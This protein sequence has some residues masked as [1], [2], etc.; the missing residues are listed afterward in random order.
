MHKSRLVSLLK[1][2]NKQEF[3][4]L[5]RF[6]RSPFFNNNDEVIALYDYLKNNN[7]YPNFTA[8]VLTKE[9][10]D[11]KVFGKYTLPYEYDP[12]RIRDCMSHL[13]LLVIDF[14]G[15]IE[16]Q[17]ISGL[18]KDQLILKALAKR[19]LHKLFEDKTT[20]A[21]QGLETN[22]IVDHQYYKLMFELRSAF[23]FHPD[24]PKLQQSAQAINAVMENLDLFYALSKLRISCEL[25]SREHILAEQYH[26]DL[27]DEIIQL[28]NIKYQSHTCLF[29]IYTNLISLFS[30]GYQAVIYNESKNL[31]FENLKSIS[32][33]E[34]KIILH[35]LIN[36]VSTGVNKG[37]VNI[38]EVFELYKSGLKH[39]VLI[40]NKRITPE[41]FSNISVL[42]S[43][44]GAFDWT[45]QFMNDYEQFLDEDIRED[46]KLMSLA[47]WYFN[48]KEFD[49]TIE[50][51]NEH[52]LP[53]KIFYIR[54]RALLIRT[55]LE[56]YIEDQLFYQILS[57]NTDAFRKQVERNKLI[58]DN[59]K[60]AY[61]NFIKF[62]KRIVNLIQNQP[63]RL[64]Q[65]LKKLELE[66]KQTD[67]VVARSWL[68]Q[69]IKE[70][71][72]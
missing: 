40:L 69:K 1:S 12:R 36:I 18:V 32:K 11:K 42:G 39:Q 16:A 72:F 63:T 70:I 26:I 37:L 52:Q 13:S 29:Q 56:K 21:I 61:K 10:V 53:G 20:Q 5:G 24:T 62:I 28:S 54:T 30:D 38:Q 51:I 58:S 48:K 15:I 23:F 9:Q 71:K 57:S 25:R 59:K 46:T 8:P 27:I 45:R 19:N 2:L 17:D 55:Y 41:S 7:H 65:K 4:R 47:Y 31:Y 44:L 22:A 67:M 66:L 14:I 64:E 43:K 34:Q 35:Y 50:L 33:E 60:I 6:L 3:R 49:Q 68:I